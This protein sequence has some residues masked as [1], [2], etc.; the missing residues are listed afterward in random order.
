MSNL[1]YKANG[2][3]KK[4]LRVVIATI[5][6]DSHTWNLVFLELLFKNHDCDTLN[7]GCCTPYSEI[8]KNSKNIDL[9]VISTVNGHGYSEGLELI[10]FLKNTMKNTIPPIIIGGKLG[11]KGSENKQYYSTLLN[12]GYSAVFDDSV[13][14]ED[15]EKYIECRKNL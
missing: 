11:V 15:F 10:Q 13:P 7:L 3:N 5:P 12:S 6:S 9:V 8:Q 2:I 14:I 1:V 4:R